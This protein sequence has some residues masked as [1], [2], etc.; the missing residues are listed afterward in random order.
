[1]RRSTLISLVLIATGA[2]IC[3][4]WWVE[5]LVPAW[6]EFLN[7]P[8]FNFE[9]GLFSLAITAIP[10]LFGWFLIICGILW[11]FL[12]RMNA[13]EDEK[14]IEAVDE[15]VKVNSERKGTFCENCGNSLKPTAKFCGS[16]GNQV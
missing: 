6:A 13:Q 14:M 1:M 4:Y 16:C 9:L 11:Y 7:T 8:A 3:W 5:Y 2:I 15:I 12:D 10:F